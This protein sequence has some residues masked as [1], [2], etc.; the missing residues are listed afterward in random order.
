[1]VRMDAN[2][3]C[4]P[5]QMGRIAK[6]KAAAR[7]A[8]KRKAVTKSQESLRKINP[9]KKRERPTCLRNKVIPMLTMLPITDNLSNGRRDSFCNNLMKCSAS[10]F[11]F[12][13]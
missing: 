4:F 13:F 2:G 6:K 5:P 12:V 7:I 9:Y 8:P 11:R 3:L 10:L 1:M